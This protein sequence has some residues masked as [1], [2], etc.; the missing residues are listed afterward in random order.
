M[1]E[2]SKSP[3]G[4]TPRKANNIGQKVGIGNLE[5]IP[6]DRLFFVATKDG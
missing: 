4:E 6:M 5:S 3:Y 2:R 1:V